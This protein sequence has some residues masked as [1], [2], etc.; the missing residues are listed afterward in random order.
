MSRSLLCS[1]TLAW[2]FAPLALIVAAEK[3]QEQAVAEALTGLAT[4]FNKHDASAVAAHW[5][6]TGV[7]TNNET[8]ETTTGRD[9]I[10][11]MY[12]ATFEAGGAPSL[13]VSCDKVRFITPDVATVDGLAAVTDSED[14]TTYSTFT[15]VVV[16]QD[17]KWLVDSAHETDLPPNPKPADYLA[18]L[19]WMEGEWVD[20]SEDVSI[21][22]SVRW[23]PKRAFLIRSYRVVRE[24]KIA[25]EGTQVFGWDPRSESIRTWMFGSDGGFGEGAVTVDGDK[26]ST[27]IVGVLAD[28][29]EAS[30]TQLFTVIDENS[31]YSQLVGH[32]IDGEPQPST[33]AVKVV[34]VVADEESPA[35]ETPELP[36]KPENKPAPKQ[37]KQ[38]GKKA[39][40]KPDNKPSDK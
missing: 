19:A 20:E 4:A 9:A 11:K 13:A 35:V 18:P 29:R 22:T 8:G 38:P 34:R 10:E 5:S 40:K 30:A 6:K 1:L 12:A 16:K 33:E 31:F 7:H 15:A 28:G 14:E 3:S 27:K 32:D 21:T 17:N 23:S 39:E 2:C 36:A 24:D 37:E 26:V 25:H